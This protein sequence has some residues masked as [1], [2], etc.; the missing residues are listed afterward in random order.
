MA[1]S[2]LGIGLPASSPHVPEARREAI[3]KP[4]ED[5]QAEM[6]ASPYDWEM[7]YVDTDQPSDILTSKLRERDWDVVILGSK[8]HDSLYGSED[9]V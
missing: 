8:W 2:V 5:T 9:S 6:Q 4:L 7:L 1:P 3:A